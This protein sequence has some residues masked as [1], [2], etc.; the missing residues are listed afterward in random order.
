[1]FM[2]SKLFAENEKEL[3]TLKLAVRIFSDD[4]GMEFA[5]FKMKSR[6]R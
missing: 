5:M 2:D 3:K 6:K 4:I 1:M